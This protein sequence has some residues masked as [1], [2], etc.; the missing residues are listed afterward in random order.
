LAAL[1]KANGSKNALAKSDAMGGTFLDNLSV[2]KR[3]FVGAQPVLHSS[4]QCS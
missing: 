3:T 1:A 4:L 2:Q